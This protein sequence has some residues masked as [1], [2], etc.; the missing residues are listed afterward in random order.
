MGK[1]YLDLDVGSIE[2]AEAIY[3]SLDFEYAKEGLARVKHRIK[4][5]EK[6]FKAKSVSIKTANGEMFLLL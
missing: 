2:G 6:Q 1:F 5:F 3:Y 4:A